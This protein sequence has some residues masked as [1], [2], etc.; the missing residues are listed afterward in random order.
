M[1]RRW[2]KGNTHTHT[3]YSDGDSPPDLVVDW[4]EAHGYDFLF[5]TD[6]N[7]LIPDDHL[8]RLQR[9]SMPVWQG[10]EVTMAAVHVNGLGVTELIA[11]PWPGKSV[12]EPE[13][14]H[15]HDHRVRWAVEQILAQGAVAH[16]NHPNYLFTLSIDDLKAA[17][18]IGLLE[19]ANG[20]PGVNNQGNDTSP[21]TEVIWDTLLT[22][23]GRIWGVASDDAHHFQTWGET[24]SNP[25]RGWLQV[26][27]ESARL[28]DVLQALRDGRFYCSSGLELS[29]YEAS[30][31]EV[32]L[33]LQG[34]SATIELIGPGGAILETVSGE[35]AHFRL[36][37]VG[38]Y[39]RIRATAPDG[40]RLWTQPIFR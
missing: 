39:A 30:A 32:S 35:R 34:D 23:G 18:E 29:A 25:G 9:A 20:H 28:G 31:A 22:D 17:G 10:E 26:E 13:I 38:T 19:V 4:Y 40:R 6:H 27:A 3:Q 24:Y 1:A 37:A 16:V 11:P 33:E 8:A 15:S 36:S 5:L 12:R 2:L 7:I 21:A 14:E